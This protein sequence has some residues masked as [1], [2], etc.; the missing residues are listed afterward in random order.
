LLST[1]PAEDVGFG[2]GG[3]ITIWRIENFAKA[4]FDEDLYGQ[5]WGG[6]SYVVLYA[7][8]NGDQEEFAIYFW[9][10]DTSS[11]DERGAAAI[12]AQEL[13]DSMGGSPVQVRGA[14]KE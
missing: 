4:P 8:M 10:G 13:D 3:K 2:K 7:Y 1:L 12:M 9:L 14:G 6:D 11:Q 5:F